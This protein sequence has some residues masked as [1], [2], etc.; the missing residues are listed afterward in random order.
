MNIFNS[1]Y[2]TAFALAMAASLTACG[3]DWLDEFPAS[4]VDQGQAIT[5]AES[6]GTARVGMYAALKGNST[7]TDYYGRTFFVYG[8][9]RGEDIQYNP[10]T[11]SNRGSLYY[12]QT[13]ST[14]SSFGTDNTPWQSPY[15]VI[16]RANLML[17]AIEQGRMP[18]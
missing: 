15:M 8:D 4:G 14:A 17:D 2:K 16:S 18:T 5:S 13:Y 11:G 10:V 1:L 7:N 3:N 6:L 9:V 12:Y